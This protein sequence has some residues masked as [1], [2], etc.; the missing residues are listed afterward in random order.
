MDCNFIKNNNNIS[1]TKYAK[2]NVPI[3][4]Q[5]FPLKLWTTLHNNASCKQKMKSNPT[6]IFLHGIKAIQLTKKYIERIL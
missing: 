6:L 4:F 5:F 1:S 3:F 2:N